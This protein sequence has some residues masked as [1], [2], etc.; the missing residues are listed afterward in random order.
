MTPELG[1][2]DFYPADKTAVLYYST[3]D[4]ANQEYKKKLKG[5]FEV[6]ITT[7]ICKLIEL[8][9]KIQFALRWLSNFLFNNELFKQSCF[10]FPTYDCF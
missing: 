7:F 4:Y 2:V 8:D 6:I 9:W 3:S 5:F 10:L 1:F